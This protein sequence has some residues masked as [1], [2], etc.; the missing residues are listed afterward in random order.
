MKAML[1]VFFDKNGAVH[2][3]FVPERQTVSGAFYVEVLK[4]LKRRVNRV[5]ADISTK[6]KLHHDNAPSHTCFVVTEHLT[7]NGFVTIL[8]PH[9]S[10]HLVPAEFFSSPKRKP[11]SEGATMGLWMMSKGLARML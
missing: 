1:I 3:E 5:R 8:Q 2:S 4:R 7:K 10:P 9:Y 6:C 11:P